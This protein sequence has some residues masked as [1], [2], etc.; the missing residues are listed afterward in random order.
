MPRP[1][2]FQPGEVA[3]DYGSATPRWVVVVDYR[4]DSRGRGEYRVIRLSNPTNGY[5]HGP[6]FWVKS[7]RLH[8]TDWTYKRAVSVYRNN[9]AIG[10][11]SD[12]GCRCYCCIHV[13]TPAS[14]V[15]K[16][17]TFKWESST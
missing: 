5:L 8:P 12:R 1:L 6:A 7:Y 14:D 17:G 13:A 15:E 3:E 4:Q 9:Q 16:D 2:K 10:D 11:G